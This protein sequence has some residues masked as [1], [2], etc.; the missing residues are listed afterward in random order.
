MNCH[1]FAQNTQQVEQFILSVLD[2]S[3]DMLYNKKEIF[4]EKYLL[5]YKGNMASY[6]VLS[7]LKEKLL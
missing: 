5:P 2:S 1:E 4:V 3:E 6:N 7:D